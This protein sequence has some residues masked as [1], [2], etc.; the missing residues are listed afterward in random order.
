MVPEARLYIAGNV[1]L[2]W[3]A[4]LAN[5]GLFLM[6]GGFL[7]QLLNNDLSAG[8]MAQTALFAAGVIIVRLLCQ[9]GAQRLGQ[10]ASFAAKTAIRQTVYQ[11]LISLGPS[12]KE[13][14]STSEALQ[15]SVEGVEHLEV[16]FGAYVPQLFYA[17]V[18]P[19]TLFVCL[20]PLSLPA[21]VTLLICVPLIP[22]SIMAVQRIAKRVMGRYWGSY[23]DLGALFLESIQGLTTLKVF[24]ADEARHKAMNAE[25][26]SFRQATMR[27]LVMQLNSITVMDLFAFGAAAIGI[28]VALFQMAAGEA[29]FGAVF[30]IIFLSADF[31]LPMRMLGSLFHTAMSGMSAADR[32]FALIDA[33]APP[34]GTRSISPAQAD[35]ECRGV[36]YAYDEG[37]PVLVDVDL[38]IPHGSFVGI[39]G[40]SGSGK[41]T[42]AGVLCGSLGLYDG[43]VCIG[44]VDARELSRACLRETITYVPFASYLFEGTIRS[45]L[46]LAK[47]HA[48]DAE[49]MEVLRTCRLDAFVNASGGLDA[50][51]S[52]EGANLSGGQRQ[53][54]ALARALLHDTP[55]YI[56]DEATSNVD[57]ESEA[58]MIA[59]IEEIANTKTV[60]MIT[61]R[62]SALQRADRIYV[63]EDGRVAEMGTHA[64]LAGADGAYG[65]LWEK[66]SQLETFAQNAQNDAQADLQYE[67][68]EGFDGGDA[69]SAQAAPD[70]DHT[71][72][73]HHGVPLK[74]RS[75]LSVM[76]GLVGL[77]RP[78][79]PV[80]VCA[81]ILGVLGFAAAIFLTVFAAYGLLDL[82][83]SSEGL[84]WGT[85]IVAL[86]ICGVVRGPLRYGEQLCNHYLAFKILALVRD[87]LFAHMRR[88]AP[89]KLEGRNQG[90][91]VSLMT[92][93]VELLEVFYA[94][95]LSPAAI[96]LLVSIGMVVFIAFLSPLL[97]AFAAFCYIVIGIVIPWVS[98][99]AAG[100]SGRDMRERVSSMSTF[101]LDS[102]RGLPEILQFGR[103]K[104]RSDQLLQHASELR[105][106]EEPLK[107]RTAISSAF[108]GMVILLMDVAMLFICA[109]EVIS[110]A[111][112]FGAAVLALSALMSSFGPVLAVAGLGTTLQQTLASGARVLDLLD[113]EPVVEEVDAGASLDGFTGAALR[114]VDFSYGDES[115]LDGVDLQ[116]QPGSVVRIDGRSGAGKSTLLKMLMRFW[117]VDNGVVELS[118][119]DVRCINTS[120]L[121]RMEGFMSQ[122]TFLFTG[123]IRDNLALAKPDATDDEMKEALRKASVLDTVERLPQGLDTPV[124]EV[125]G[126]F[127]GGERQRLGLARVFLQ[128]APFMLLDEPTSN[129]DA[130]NEAAVLKAVADNKKGHTIVLV[131]H[132]PSARAI[133]DT[134]YSIAG[135]AS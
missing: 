30:S 82:A 60:I 66:Q 131:S 45:N 124:E 99:K 24:Q 106:A 44:G 50:P 114:H 42:L 129:L 61:H 17:L 119:Q 67:E 10:K 2:Q 121:R 9:I 49:L 26:E 34:S 98:S 51:V 69:P 130:L 105:D 90:N 108:T 47:P 104:E 13:H 116:I 93:D 128:D 107:R 101:V 70:S 95:T 88:L 120:D 36:G 23:T 74:R 62:L 3:V 18:A 102:L 71:E 135:R 112:P 6:I 80:M 127:S 125:G 132:R 7:Q 43:T 28:S 117:D 91:L 31:F 29:G 109:F 15:I 134:T 96:A 5:I 32:M 63:L 38:D 59:S 20:V 73:G 133:S 12:Y 40:E 57:A 1:F 78:L 65:R 122:D 8:S 14:I 33:P 87:R 92:Q 72:D 81:I 75:H 27:L 123:T 115:I 86:I 111:L 46:E 64:D 53:R 22:A 16:Y 84:T 103:A 118:G 11:K 21:A 68:C 19:L 4:L 39:T 94:H 97:A 35:I 76:L 41:S 126:N 85:A 52:A 110:G 25:A 48:T 58:A 100:G 77:T 55:I 56:L 89:A 113:E 37:S 83:G 54:L 79:L